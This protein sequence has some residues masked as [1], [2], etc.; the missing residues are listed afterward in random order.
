MN[1]DLA[2][3]GMVCKVPGAESI[4]D[5][6]SMLCEGREGLRPLSS[7]ECKST[8]KQ[9]A[10]HM[11]YA[12]GF[13][14]DIDRF[15]PELFGYT[16]RD[17]LYMD[18]Q[19]RLFLQA[20]WEALEVS[21]NAGNSLPAIGVFATSSF[22]AY[23]TEVILKQGINEQQQQSSKPSNKCQQPCECQRESFR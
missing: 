9:T 5:F 15:D 7:E 14:K 13:L 23:L 10:A 3:V 18:P 2:I 6:W 11:V 22:N 17:A 21:A 20:C 16:A 8:V 1:R 19:Q 12:G 4:A